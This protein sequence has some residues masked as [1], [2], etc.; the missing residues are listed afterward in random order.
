MG[1]EKTYC[2]PEFFLY[3]LIST[4]SRSVFLERTQRAPMILADD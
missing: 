1:T 3:T 2:A 4:L